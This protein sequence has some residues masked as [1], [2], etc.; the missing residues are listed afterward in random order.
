M[1]DIKWLFIM[2]AWSSTHFNFSSLHCGSRKTLERKMI[3]DSPKGLK[4]RSSALRCEGFELKADAKGLQSSA[5][6]S[7]LDI[8][9]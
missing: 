8:L 1:Y 3:P 5:W 4:L 6:I 7:Q 2:N 9:Q